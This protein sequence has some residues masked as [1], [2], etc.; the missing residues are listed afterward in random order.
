MTASADHLVGA[1]AAG[2]CN[3]TERL[4]VFINNFALY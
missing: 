3:Y 2:E 4:G 1:V